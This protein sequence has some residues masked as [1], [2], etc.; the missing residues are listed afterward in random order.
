MPDIAQTGGL[1]EAFNPGAVPIAAAWIIGTVVAVKLLARMIDRVSVR[2]ISQR[3]ILKQASTLIAFV[4]YTVSFILAFNAV[5]NLSSE[6]LF[7]LSGTLAVTAGFALKDVAAS[8]LAGITILINKPFQV[9]DRI[10]FGGYYGEV[11][12]IGLRS[13]R[14]VTLDDNL[15]TVP[16]NKF[17]TDPVASANAGALDCMVVIEFHV[18]VTA[19]HGRAREI[20]RDAVVASKYLF[21]EKPFTVLVGEHLSERGEV[22]IRLTAKAYVFDMQFEKAFSSDVTDRVLTAFRNEGLTAR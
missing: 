11:K 7:A 4:A 12:E 2:L 8:F 6:A 17:L 15:V 13:I 1:L 18:P 14:I 22:L 16:S 19:D 5:F 21:L 9:G 20:V 10:S 3:L